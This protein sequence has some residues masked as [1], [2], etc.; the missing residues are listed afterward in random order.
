[1]NLKSKSN[2]NKIQSP[3]KEED[4]PEGDT[5]MIYQMRYIGYQKNITMTRSQGIILP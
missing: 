1:M 2:A 4:N 5:F 3:P